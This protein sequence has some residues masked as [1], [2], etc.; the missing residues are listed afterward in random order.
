MSLSKLIPNGLRRLFTKGGDPTA[1]ALKHTSAVIQLAGKG[2]QSTPKVTL[3]RAS[4]LPADLVEIAA[5]NYAE[6]TGIDK[7]RIIE[8]YLFEYDKRDYT[9]RVHGK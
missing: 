1:P 4:E 6:L 5:R 8:T 9:V 7:L 3:A 2:L